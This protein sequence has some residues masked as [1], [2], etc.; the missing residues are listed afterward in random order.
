MNVPLDQ[1]QER[2]ERHFEAL[3]KSR[4]T[5]GLP[6]FALEHGL[7]SED[8]ESV[9]SQLRARLTSGAR[10]APHWLLWTIY[11]AEHGYNYEGGEYW[12]SFE[13]NT[14]GWDA[15]DRYRVSTWF[16]RFQK[17]FNGFR[18]SGAW[19]SHFSIIAWP[20]THAVLPRYLQR[21]FARTLYVLRFQIARTDTIEPA[22]VGSLIAANAHDASTRFEQFLQQKELV[23]RIALALLELE[24]AADGEEPLLPAT[25]SRIVR[26][27][28]TIRSARGWLNETSRVVSDRF[29]GLGNGTGLHE[30]IDGVLAQQEQARLDIRPDLRLHYKGQ[31]VWDL[32]I[33]IPSFNDVAALNPEV[34]QFLKQTR[35]VLNGASSKKPPG[36]LLSAR[37]R[38]VLRNWP[39]PGLPLVGF[40][41]QNGTVTHL[42]E[43]ECR[44]GEGPHWLFRIGR[45][46]IAKEI[47]GRIVRPG[48]E[49]VIASTEPFEDLM[50]G[51]TPCVINCPEIKAVHVDVPTALPE[52]YEHWLTAKG[53]EVART[54]RVW[55]A[56]FPGRQWDGEGHSEWLTTE[57]PCFGIV[58]DHDV[59]TYEISLNGEESLTIRSDCPGTPT[60]VQLPEL[61]SGRHLLTVRAKRAGTP[62]ERQVPQEGFLELRVREPMPWIPG[63]A[64]HAG[65]IVSGQPYNAALSTFWENE[66]E[67]SVFGP[68]SRQVTPYV[69]LQN[70][71]EETF[72]ERQVCDPLEFP[73][74]PAVWKKRF[75]EFL[76]REKCEWRYLEA[77]LGFLAL[78][79]GDLGRYVIRFEHDV[80]PLRW[81]LSHSDDDISVRLVDETGKEEIEWR[82]YYFDMGRPRSSRRL[83]V[84]LALKGMPVDSPGG[85]FVAKAGK[86]HEA[87]VV[88]TGL[89]GEG[90]GGLGVLP[91]HG[92][93]SEEPQDIIELLWILRYWHRAKVAGY[94]AGA[95]RRQVTD[96]L[97]HGIVGVMA[98]WD[99]ARV[100]A[101][102]NGAADP[103]GYMDHLQSL[104][105]QKSGFASA[106][107]LNVPDLPEGQTAIPSWYTAAASRYRISADQELCR[108]ATVFASRPYDLPLLFPQNLSDLIHRARSHP[109]LIRGAR[110][111][112]FSRM[113]A[114]VNSPTLLPEV[115]T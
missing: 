102:L 112:V 79:G 77:S 45:D 36:W 51:M 10:L 5:S 43:S 35:C 11:A 37:R 105:A 65:L 15:S 78:D 46:G 67:L 33:D 92:H 18:P 41:K 99:W 107:R 87:V 62:A 95:R 61:S 58:P 114:S 23:G 103:A 81:V 53:L 84:D 42:L 24:K 8:I 93:I 22:V 104:V 71:G 68:P 21:Q 9:S 47:R 106:I 49:Y 85:L 38:A 27:L 7:S 13:Q 31:G 80:R 76:R 56:G 3:A 1:W 26:D 19:A 75:S 44:M 28:E 2:M 32:Q 55:P 101:K 6:L 91:E 97:M 111:A 74:P 29:K 59:E 113:T 40:E 72:F 115:N 52:T 14:P 96:T 34:R 4:E 83:D 17:S 20:I 64:S 48:Y 60:F 88:S 54:I 12:Q 25:L 90:L 82:C 109:S 70:A 39:D 57:R 94:L 63:T 86:N 73:V 69:I 98:G 100:E 30:K 108:F 50:E 89:T 66:F 110:L 16:S